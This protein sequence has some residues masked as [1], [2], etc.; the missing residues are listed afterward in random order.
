MMPISGDQLVF[1]LVAAI[2]LSCFGNAFAVMRRQPWVVG[3]SF[4]LWG[5]IALSISY[6]AYGLSPWFGRVSLV[7]ANMTFLISYISLTLQLRFWRTTKSNVPMWVIIASLIYVIVFEVVRDALPYSA[8][9]TLGQCTILLLTGYLVW[10]SLS[11][12]KKQRSFQILMLSGTFAVEFL[13]AGIRLAMLW[14]Q[15]EST[16]G[17]SS[18]LSEPFYMIVVRWVWAAS[19]AI[20]YLTVMTY[21]LEKTFD[22]NEDLRVLLKEKR[23]LINALSKVSR[24]HHA[25]DVASA[26]THELSQ[27]LTTLLLLTKSLSLQIKDNDL[28]DL[29]QQVDILRTESERSANIMAQIHKLLRVQNENLQPIQIADVLDNALLVLS[30]RLSA[31]NITL[32]KVGRFDYFVSGEATQLELVF[33]NLISNAISILS[34]QEEQRHIELECYVKNS[35]CIVEVKDNGPG[36]DQAI[37]QSIGQIY[38]S[39][40]EQG[41][42]VGLWLTNLILANHRGKLEANN[43]Q[44]GG[45]SFRVT[46]PL[47]HQA[48]TPK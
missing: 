26:L 2:L 5:L 45:A 1:L 29:Q 47:L 9:A 41:S 4:W 46:L 8:R 6:L 21:V 40:R 13:C 42:G 25:G 12:Y 14:L 11:F 7:I 24:S 44:N 33:I 31:N 10:S 16:A 28:K 39:G 3:E 37:L 20:S 19:N 23:Q 17:T 43:R 22:R 27:P 38:V 15:P 32:K 35:H 48:R 34:D 30:P 18:I 36:I